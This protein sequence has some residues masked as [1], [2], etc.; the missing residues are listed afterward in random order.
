[1]GNS[2]PAAKNIIQDRSG[3]Q[4]L[5]KAPC[6]AVFRT[7]IRQA[8]IHS[9]ISLKNAIASPIAIMTITPTNSAVTPPA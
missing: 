2:A 3:G 1:M 8:V 6:D 4:C 7:L 9:V 5:D